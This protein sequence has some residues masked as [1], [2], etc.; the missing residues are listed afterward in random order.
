VKLL[1]LFILIAEKLFIIV[2]YA[3]KDFEWMG[4]KLK[5]KRPRPLWTMPFAINPSSTHTLLPTKQISF[6][7]MNE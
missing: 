7:G 4:N 2:Y 3:F 6:T 1:H 5:R